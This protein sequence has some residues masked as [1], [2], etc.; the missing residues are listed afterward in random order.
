MM[1]AEPVS[2]TDD[3]I[4][5]V[6]L[7]VPDEL[8]DMSGESEK[9]ALAVELVLHCADADDVS[10]EDVLGVTLRDDVGERVRSTLLESRGEFDVVGDRDMLKLTVG[11]R[12]ER[13]DLE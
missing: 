4:E 3:E 2:A 6:G 10:D 11:D 7:I 5:L 8:S 9:L 13:G 12:L 1:V